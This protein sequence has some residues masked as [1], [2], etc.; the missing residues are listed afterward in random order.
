MQILK[1]SR[2]VT[3]CR[4]ASN[5]YNYLGVP[6]TAPSSVLET[7]IDEKVREIENDL[8]NE[9]DQKRAL[10]QI[11]RIK[12]ILLNEENRRNYNFAERENI[13]QS[14]KIIELG[15]CLIKNRVYIIYFLLYKE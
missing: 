4:Q 3:R 5:Y 9:I 1:I 10:G 14:I 2:L 12:K 6:H 15:N 13:S 8:E 7:A 11:K